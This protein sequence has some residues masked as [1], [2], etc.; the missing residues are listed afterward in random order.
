MGHD[1][2]LIEFHGQPLIQHVIRRVENLADEI[3]VTTNDPKSYTFLNLPLF[4]DIILDRG[5]LGGL[6]TALYSANHPLVAVIA[7]DMPFVNPEILLYAVNRFNTGDADIVLPRTTAGYEPFHA[8]Y[9][10]D[11]CLVPIKK[12]LDSGKWRVDSWFSDVRLVLIT[13]NKIKQLDLQ[14]LSFFNI[15]TPDDLEFARA[16]AAESKNEN[17]LLHGDKL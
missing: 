5:A 4:R 16:I 9:L 3:L 7:A 15:N 12:A 6:Y 13:A 1:K 8:V 17:N 10:R 2:A 11:A 14:G